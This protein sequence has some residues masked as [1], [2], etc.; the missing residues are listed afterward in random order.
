M[1]R[2]YVQNTLDGDFHPIQLVLFEEML[3]INVHEL[4]ISEY[5]L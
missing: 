3:I 5:L 4:P 2:I 1:C